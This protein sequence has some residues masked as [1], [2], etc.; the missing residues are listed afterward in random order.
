[1]SAVTMP[2]TLFSPLQSAQV[3]QVSP[4]RQAELLLG[5]QSEIARFRKGHVIFATVNYSFSAAYLLAPP[6]LVHQY[7]PS[8]EV[9]MKSIH[10]LEVRNLAVMVG[11]GLFAGSASSVLWEALFS[12]A[13]PHALSITFAVGGFVAG[14]FVS[15]LAGKDHHAAS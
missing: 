13:A 8:R 15:H 2:M 3:D 5:T 4:A 14:G 9:A 7:E 12:S 1:M 11:M 10:K 6:I